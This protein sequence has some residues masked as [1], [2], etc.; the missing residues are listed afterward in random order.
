MEREL[1]YR[2]GPSEFA[3]GG[4]RGGVVPG[5]FSEAGARGGVAGRGIAVV[6]WVD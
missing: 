6:S 4:V 2:S 3:A 1:G 5:G